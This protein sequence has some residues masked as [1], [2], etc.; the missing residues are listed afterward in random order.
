M[1][2]KGVLILNWL[3]NLLASCSL[4]NL[5]FSS[6]ALD[7][8]TKALYSQYCFLK[9]LGFTLYILSALPAI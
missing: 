3:N 1:L 7:A 5:D 9:L 2:C 4:I 8:L 6:C